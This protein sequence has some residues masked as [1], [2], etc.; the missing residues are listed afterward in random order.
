MKAASFKPLRHSG[1]TGVSLWLVDLDVYAAHVE[2]QGLAADEHARAARMVF[3]QGAQ[4]YLA[5][6][7]ALRRLLA[8]A[9]ARP[10][11]SLLIAASENGKPYL[12]GDSKIHFNLSHSENAALI[13]LSTE[14]PIGVDI[15]VVRQIEN[16]EALAQR[17]F[18]YAERAELS[19]ARTHGDAAFLRCWTR[20]EACMKALGVGL[21][22]APASLETGCTAPMRE[23]SVPLGPDRC[24][25][26]VF[27]VDM[28]AEAVAALAVA[29][30]ADVMR[31][32]RYF[33]RL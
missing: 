33:S 30:S 4:R 25:V 1:P 10:A 23:V 11:H 12:A 5:S 27:G 17:H 3:Q 15:E 26:S 9:V 18:T 19:L 14:V 16:R 8:N 13:G 7:H 24:S 29:A 28:P 2:L 32:Q 6:R 31:A 22:V 21:A 20:K